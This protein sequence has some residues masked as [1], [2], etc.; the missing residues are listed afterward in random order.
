MRKKKHYRKYRTP[1]TELWDSR[2][3]YAIQCHTA[4]ITNV[5]NVTNVHVD[6]GGAWKH[7]KHEHKRR[8]RP[9]ERRECPPKLFRFCSSCGILD[10]DVAWKMSDSQMCQEAANVIGY[11]ARGL[12]DCVCQGARE[13]SH[14]LGVA[15]RGV[16]QIFE[17]LFEMFCH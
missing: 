7:R 5:T 4:N 17:G 2:N 14:H 16:G 9:S 15:A 11:S 12:T 13:V 8:D 1:R 3:Q 10:Q 6:G